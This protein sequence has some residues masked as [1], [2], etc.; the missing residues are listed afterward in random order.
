MLFRIFF[1]SKYLFLFAVLSIVGWWTTAII[2]TNE[3]FDRLDGVLMIIANLVNILSNYLHFYVF[4]SKQDLYLGAFNLFDETDN[5]FR[6]INI[7][8][9]FSTWYKCTIG[10]LVFL[11]VLFPLHV[12]AFTYL[13][14]STVAVQLP[15]M[16]GYGGGFMIKMFSF[17]Y[18]FSFFV[19]MILRF[20]K[21]N[22]YLMD[23][24]CTPPFAK[25]QKEKFLLAATIH[26]NLCK[27]AV[28]INKS[29]G[30]AIL[31]LLLSVFIIMVLLMVAIF[32]NSTNRIYEMIYWWMI[33]MVLICMLS[34]VYVLIRVESN[35]TGRIFA[36]MELTHFSEFLICK[37][38]TILLQSLHFR[39]HLQICNLFYLDGKLLLG[40]RKRN[41]RYFQ[42]VIFVFFS[43][44]TL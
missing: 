7:K 12:L 33:H 25:M 27:I 44:L 6:K 19:F 38:N 43:I 5:L 13:L 40:V 2:I 10:S 3:T 15:R 42:V 9:D 35:R 41:K 34:T 14:K 37:R 24:N 16:I 21:L 28:D 23:Y 17:Y 20:R 4:L 22:E 29:F 8:F 32:Y 30:M 11:Y 36:E 26:Y 18:S 39:L 1:D 31:T